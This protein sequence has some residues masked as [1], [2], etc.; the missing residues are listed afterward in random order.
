MVA[1]LS[2]GAGIHALPQIAR[3][4]AT[5]AAVRRAAGLR[6]GLAAGRAA[7]RD[8]HVHRADHP[9]HADAARG[10]GS[11]RSYLTALRDLCRR[12]DVSRRPGC[13]RCT[14]SGTVL[15]QYFGM[16]EVT[17]NITVLPPH[18]HSDRGRRHAGRQLRL[19]AHRHGR[20]RSW[21]TTGEHLP[22][23][24]DRRDLR[25]RPWR[26][27]RLPRQSRGHREGHRASAGSIPATSV[28]W[29]SAAFVYITG[30]ASDMYISGGSNVYPREDRGS[31][32]LHPRR[33]R[34]LRRRHAARE[35]G[36]DRRRRAG[37]GGGRDR[38]AT[39][40]LLAHLEGRLARYKWPARFVFW[41][42]LPKSGYGKVTKRDVK[43]LL[44]ETA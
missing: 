10:S 2:H 33:R 39:A 24:D 19:P 9:D 7:S 8:Q 36:R 12:A 20:S 41:P 25:A 1:P 4:A 37:A 16:G 26:V 23:G 11:L 21:M 30:R 13:M 43:R 14:S 27:R 5:R 32:L 42:E 6:G 38:P 29:T 15:V 44:E 35:M 34:G 18:L 17:G 28:I 3:G 31:L 22:P 40:N